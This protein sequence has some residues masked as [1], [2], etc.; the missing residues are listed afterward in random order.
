MHM[1]VHTNSR[2]AIAKSYDEIGGFPP[3]TF[4]L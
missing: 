2:L 3:D 4:E 1:R